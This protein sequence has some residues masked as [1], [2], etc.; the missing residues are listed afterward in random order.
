MFE[1]FFPNPA[2]SG[3]VA[4]RRGRQHANLARQGQSRFKVSCSA[5]SIW[6]SDRCSL[7]SDSGAS[8]SVGIGGGT[9]VIEAWYFPSVL[10]MAGMFELFN[11]E[12][13]NFRF[14]ITVRNG[15][16]TATS[17]AFPDKASAVAGIR[18]MREYAGKGHITD[19]CLP[20]VARAVAE[21]WL[22]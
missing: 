2:L 3:G 11:D 18:D 6:P 5:N 22:Q 8:T 19:M 12:Y 20:R 4:P 17:C 10:T 15:A 16:V 7:F 1:P 21:Q 13:S 9:G 14:R